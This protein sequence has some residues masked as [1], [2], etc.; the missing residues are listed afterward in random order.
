M[1]CQENLSADCEKLLDVSPNGLAERKNYLRQESPATLG[2]Q[3][4]ANLKRY[5][6]DD[7]ACITNLWCK[8]ILSDRQLN[9]LM[10]GE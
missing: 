3:A 8:G 2:E 4:I 6:H 1:I 9:V 10:L 5:L 7:Y